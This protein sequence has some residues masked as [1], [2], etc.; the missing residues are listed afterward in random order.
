MELQPYLDQIGRGW[1]LIVGLSDAAIAQR[2][3]DIKNYGYNT[4][5]APVKHAD[6]YI[7]SMLLELKP[8]RPVMFRYCTQSGATGLVGLEMSWDCQTISFC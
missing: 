7:A 3:H 6:W 1:P 4:F 8:G 5:Y 2:R